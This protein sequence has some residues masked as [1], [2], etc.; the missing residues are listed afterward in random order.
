MYL[1][2]GKTKKK[3]RYRKMKQNT[4]WMV[5]ALMAEKPGRLV[6]K[7]FKAFT[8]AAEADNWLCSFAMKNGYSITD[9]N[10]VKITLNK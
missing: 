1:P 9:F 7:D 6:W 8:N 2:K 3:R 10:I 5:K 4:V